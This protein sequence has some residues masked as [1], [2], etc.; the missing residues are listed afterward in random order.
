MKPKGVGIKILPNF[1]ALQM[2]KYDIFYTF[3]DPKLPW[4]YGRIVQKQILL[5]KDFNVIL[6]ITFDKSC[7]FLFALA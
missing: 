6:A 7:H 3:L 1:R 2:L 5:P 4:V